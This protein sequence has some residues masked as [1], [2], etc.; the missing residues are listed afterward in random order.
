MQDSECV[1]HHMGKEGFVTRWS[2]ISSFYCIL[3]YPTAALIEFPSYIVQDPDRWVP[4]GEYIENHWREFE[5]EL[6]RASCISSCY[7]C[8]G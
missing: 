3:T 8:C 7:F 5:I 6:V 1:L 4:V 2:D